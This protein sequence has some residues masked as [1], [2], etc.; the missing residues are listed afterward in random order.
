MAKMAFRLWLRE[1]VKNGVLRREKTIR[2][3][4]ING[5][6]ILVTI[7]EG[8][9]WSIYRL[10]RF[11]VAETNFIKR[12]V[13]RDWICFDA[14]ANVGY[15]SLLFS[16]LAK[17]G[18]VHSFD[19]VPLHHHLL[20]AS[21]AINR[22]TN[23]IVNRCALGKQSG[24]SDFTISKRMGDSSFVHIETSPILEVVKVPVRTLDEYAKE[25]GTARINILKID[26]EGAEKMV[27]EGS[28]EI[29]SRKERRPN[30]LFV[31]LYD[32]HCSRYDTTIAETI[33]LLKSYEYEPFIVQGAGPIPFTPEHHNVWYNVFFV[34]R[35]DMALY[36]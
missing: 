30:V 1:T 6:S 29:L 19:P 7:D 32:A 26:V 18:A 8:L 13:Q 35:E 28:R 24:V 14:G 15:Y 25:H 2:H 11:D 34:R 5:Y 22:F 9:G 12:I 10:N 23:I 36:N 31:E 21:I 3:A 16:S 4:H 20:Q 27:L 17:D 33:A